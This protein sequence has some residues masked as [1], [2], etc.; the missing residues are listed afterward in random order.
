MGD[1]LYKTYI[2]KLQHLYTKTDDINKQTE[3]STAPI[4][5]LFFYWKKKVK[6]EIILLR[7]TS[8]PKMFHC[9]TLPTGLPNWAVF[10]AREQLGFHD[11]CIDISPS[12]I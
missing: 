1:D 11:L 5:N 8:I 9:R 4:S 3:S 2:Q 10:C 6:K 12:P 7:L